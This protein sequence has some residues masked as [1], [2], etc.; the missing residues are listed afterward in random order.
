MALDQNGRAKYWYPP[1]S[2]SPSPLVSRTACSHHSHMSGPGKPR[3]RDLPHIAVP[4]I[5]NRKAHTTSH[6]QCTLKRRSWGNW[7]LGCTTALA[8]M[9]RLSWVVGGVRERDRFALRVL[10]FGG[11]GFG[12]FRCGDLRRGWMVLLIL[13]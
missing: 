6:P 12:G 9:G 10:N 8:Q 2:R 7:P 13:L 4:P 11:G 1:I 5:S 3:A